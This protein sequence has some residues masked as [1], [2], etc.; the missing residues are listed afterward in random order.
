MHK[1]LITR[2]KSND[3]IYILSGNITRVFV[4]GQL[5]LAMTLTS[6]AF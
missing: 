5:R 3:G 4:C 2:Y 6:T 1:M